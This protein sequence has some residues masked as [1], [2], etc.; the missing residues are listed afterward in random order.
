[1]AVR[2][3]NTIHTHTH[4][5]THTRARKTL[6]GCA[7]HAACVK[8][9]RFGNT[10]TAFWSD[11][12]LSLGWATRA[13]LKAPISLSGGLP[14]SREAEREGG[15][16]NNG[17]VEKPTDTTRSRSAASRSLCAPD[18]ASSSASPLLFKANSQPLY[19][20]L[21]DSRSLSLGYKKFHDFSGTF[22]DARS[23][24]W[25]PGRKPAMLKCQDKQQLLQYTDVL[26]G[27]EQ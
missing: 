22:R 17:W 16:I 8:W 27:R 2:Q 6:L 20:Q 3:N 10:K 19:S 12:P 11:N 24:S 5:H 18:T 4:T 23:I 14:V 15:R 13:R 25:R 9:N 7:M 26:Y 21:Q 1:M